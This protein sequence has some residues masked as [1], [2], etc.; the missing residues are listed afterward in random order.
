[1]DSELE[2]MLMDEHRRREA[3]KR[4]YA[5][6]ERVQASGLVRQ[7]SCTKNQK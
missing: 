7:E 5:L 2:K 1:M 6:F 3:R 4:R